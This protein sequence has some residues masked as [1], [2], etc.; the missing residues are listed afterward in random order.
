MGEAVPFVRLLR[1]REIQ[2]LEQKTA[3][4]YT[5]IEDM[6]WLCSASALR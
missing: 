1:M 5:I 3:G 6:I 2:R 4:V